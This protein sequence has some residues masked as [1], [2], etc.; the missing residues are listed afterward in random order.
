MLCKSAVDLRGCIF[1]GG[2]LSSHS[3]VMFPR[4]FKASQSQ[5]NGVTRD[6]WIFVVKIAKTSLGK[7]LQDRAIVLGRLLVK[8]SMDRL[9]GPASS[10][11]APAS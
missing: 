5:V 11:Q 7:L 2:H 1:G 8:R 9:S 6:S 4:S 10:S 3:Y